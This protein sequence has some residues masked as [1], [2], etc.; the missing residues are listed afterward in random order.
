MRR[1]ALPIEGRYL[2]IVRAG[3]ASRNLLPR[4]PGVREASVNLATK[5][6]DVQ[7]G[8]ARALSSVSVVANAL[9]LGRRKAGATHDTKGAKTRAM[10]A[11]AQR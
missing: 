9:L 3:P 5:R 2:R 11:P 4:L 6:A 1:W 10:P 8:A 7:A